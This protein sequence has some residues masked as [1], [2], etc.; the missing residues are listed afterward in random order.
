MP[1]GKT[2]RR[3]T[4]MNALPGLAQQFELFGD[5]HPKMILDAPAWPELPIEAQVAL[6]RLLTQLILEH[7]GKNR[8]GSTREADHDL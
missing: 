4:R 6:I 2:K 7:A 5:D 8:T 1:V 3:M